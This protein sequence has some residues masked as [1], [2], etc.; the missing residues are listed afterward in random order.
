VGATVAAGAQAANI[1]LAISKTA[2]PRHIKLLF[3]STPPGL[4]FSFNG[5]GMSLENTGYERI[6]SPPYLRPGCDEQR[7]RK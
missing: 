2:R 3:M 5:N 4:K 1:T 7:S 6:C